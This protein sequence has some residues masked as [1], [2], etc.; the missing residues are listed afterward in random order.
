VTDDVF[1][2]AD[3]AALVAELRDMTLPPPPVA[4]QPGSVRDAIRVFNIPPRGKH[5][6]TPPPVFGPPEPPVR[7]MVEIEKL[8]RTLNQERMRKGHPPLDLLT[9]VTDTILFRPPWWGDNLR[10]G[11]ACTAL[12]QAWERRIAQRLDAGTDN[13]SEYP[14]DGDARVSRG[15][16]VSSRL[17]HDEHTRR[18]VEGRCLASIGDEGRALS[19]WL[20]DTHPDMPPLRPRTIENLIR[21]DHPAT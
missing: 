20:A 21:A 18:I 2:E 11:V 1:T 13:D 16:P 12:V 15:R 10:E 3:L 8:R 6:G 7:P 4:E 9:Y 14:S 19:A 17:I 5:G